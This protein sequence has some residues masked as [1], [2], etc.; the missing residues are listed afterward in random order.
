[1]HA[2][3]TNIMYNST[4][5]EEL[6]WAW[7]GWRANTG[8]LMPDMYEEYVSLLNL[9]ATMNGECDSVVSCHSI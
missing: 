7:D 2:D 6:V 3:L 1:M 4:D 8:A 5:W 9:A